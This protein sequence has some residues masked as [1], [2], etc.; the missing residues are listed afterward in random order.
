MTIVQFIGSPGYT[1]NVSGMRGNTLDQ[2]FGICIKKINN[3]GSYMLFSKKTGE[4]LTLG[5][6]VYW[7]FYDVQVKP[8]TPS[9][10][11]FL[12][13]IVRYIFNLHKVRKVY[14]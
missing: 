14:Y 4:R 10:S 8:Y 3:G 12:K 7:F 9:K 11:V 1:E 2:I 5:Y 6:S 13:A